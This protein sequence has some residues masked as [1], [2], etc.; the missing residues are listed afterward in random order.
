MIRRALS[1]LLVVVWALALAAPPAMGRLR[2]S[3][4]AGGDEQQNVTYSTNELL[5]ANGSDPLYLADGASP[6]YLADATAIYPVVAQNFKTDI[7]QPQW[8]DDTGTI[9]QRTVFDSTGALTFAGNNLVLNN[10]TL[11]TQS[12]TVVANANYIVAFYGTGSVTLSGAGSGT[13]SGTGA[14]DQVYQALTASTTTLTLTVSGTVTNA[15]VSQVTYE[16]TPRAVDQL[17]TTAAACYALRFDNT[18]AVASSPLGIKTEETRTNSLRNSTMVGAVAGSPG[19]LPTNWTVSNAGTLTRTLAVGTEYGMKYLD[20]RFNGTTSTTG[21]Q[22]SLESTTQIVAA[23]SQTWTGSFYGKLQA[24]SLTNITS[25]SIGVIER[26]SG[27]TNLAFT[28]TN[29]TPTSTITRFSG[30]RAFSSNPSIART[31][32]QITYAFSSGVAVDVTLRIYMPQYEQGTFATS[33]IPT[34][35]VATQ[36]VADIQVLTNGALSTLGGSAGT[37][38]QQFNLRANSAANQYQIYG[39]TVS[40]LYFDSALA[41]KATN[42]TTVLSSGVTAVANTPIRAGLAWDGSGRAIS[43]NGS[44]AVTD[45]NSFGTIGST[46]YDGSNNGA[47][48]ANGWIESFSVY[49]SKLTGSTF[50]TKTTTGGAL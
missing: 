34:Y 42:G 22:I 4:H 29:F 5:L 8:V 27:G 3:V 49:A 18:A 39:N 31:N 40:P 36:R 32:M 25:A 14:N 28:S 15:T 16:T 10:A 23:P 50:T 37:V 48:A 46:I 11:S 33:A 30:S 13:I 7:A 9:G 41:I 12:I 35:G 38:I 45:A 44:T 21:L 26:D 47:N 43:V 17:T 6:I 19:T 24:G 2:H 1:A 20:V